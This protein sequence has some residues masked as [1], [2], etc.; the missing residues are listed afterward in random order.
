M[1]FGHSLRIRKKKSVSLNYLILRLRLIS[2]NLPPSSVCL[3]LS[4]STERARATFDEVS[5]LTFPRL[6]K[7]CT[8]RNIFS[9][10]Y[11]RTK[12]HFNT[13]YKTNP[14]SNRI[15]VSS[16]DLNSARLNSD[17]PSSWA[18]K[19]LCAKRLT[20][21]QPHQFKR[22]CDGTATLKR[23]TGSATTIVTTPST[24]DIFGKRR[25]L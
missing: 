6:F 21:H 24:R 22:I 2:K 25:H 10:Q 18:R 20:E 14:K 12:T 15:Q 3:S 8:C 4:L 19:I 1:K 17:R 7:S 23:P 5:I 16:W 11:K 9:L 13:Y